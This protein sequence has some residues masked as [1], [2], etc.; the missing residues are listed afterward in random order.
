[1]GGEDGLSQGYEL[2]GPAFDLS[3]LARVISEVTGTSVT[4]R[5]LPVEGHT[6]KLRQAS[7]NEG[8]AHFVA[9]LDGSIARG[10]L[11]TDSQD[12]P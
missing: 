8:S 10:D 2:G 9:A 3:E 5:D 1:M 6:S 4:Y 12:L 7:L 11:E